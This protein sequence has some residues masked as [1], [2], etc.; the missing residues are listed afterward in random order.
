MLTREESELVRT[1]IIQLW[2]RD[3]LR[4]LLVN[5]FPLAFATITNMTTSWFYL[6][7]FLLCA[8]VVA[9]FGYSISSVKVP[10]LPLCERIP[11]D[12]FTPLRGSLLICLQALIVTI[13]RLCV[14]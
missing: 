10:K 4:V 1:H 13:T 3:A 6:G 14:V 2:L 9:S 7:W 12:I 5:S 11:D 8:F